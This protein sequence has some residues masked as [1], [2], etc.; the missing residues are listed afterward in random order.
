Q[1]S[2]SDNWV[3]RHCSSASEWTETVGMPSSLAAL[4]TL[5]A[6]SP[7]FAINIFLNI[8]ILLYLSTLVFKSHNRLAVFDRLAFLD[9][10]FFHLAVNFRL[11]VLQDSQNSYMTYKLPFFHNVSEFYII[12]TRFRVKPCKKSDP[13]RT[14]LVK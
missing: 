10:N 4:I 9:E 2:W 11:D 3:C 5:T 6:I 13:L 1:T 14:Q 12:F 8:I 7:L